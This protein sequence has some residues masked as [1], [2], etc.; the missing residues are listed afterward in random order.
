MLSKEYKLELYRLVYVKEELDNDFASWKKKAAVFN[1]DIKKLT[2]KD[3][4]D[5][6]E[7]VKTLC[8]IEND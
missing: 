4:I 7:L 1:A 6:S 8:E 3:K 2:G 5:W